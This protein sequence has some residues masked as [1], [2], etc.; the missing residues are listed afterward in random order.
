MQIV[1]MDML[2]T[3]LRLRFILVDHVLVVAQSMSLKNGTTCSSNTTSSLQCHRPP[4]IVT[5]LRIYNYGSIFH[6]GLLLAYK[7]RKKHDDHPCL[8][9]RCEASFS[10]HADSS[11]QYCTTSNRT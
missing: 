5:F 4:V 7:T 1:A 11:E 2:I 6:K 10:Q 8:Q 3:Q 9:L